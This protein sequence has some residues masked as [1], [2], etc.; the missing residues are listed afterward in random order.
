MSF[1]HFINRFKQIALWVYRGK[2]HLLSFASFILA[3]LYLIG[4]LKFYPGAI[5][6]FMTLTGL[7]IILTQQVI[8]ATKFGPHGPNTIAGWLK[9]FPTRKSITLDA[10]SVSMTTSIGK[11][12][13]TCSISEDETIEKKVDF[14]I[15]QI[16]ALNSAIAKV[17]D[18]VD[19]LNSSLKRSEKKFQT[20]VNTLST[21]LNN[22]IAS[23]VVG[24]YDVRLFGINITI[25]GTVIQFFS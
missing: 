19:E 12:H 4:F 17:D 25:C 20:S 6:I 5:A 7:L 2:F 13:L 11:A 23:H 24:S 14:L 15:R 1:R 21:T 3:A 8:D 22:V 18:R 16:T 10:D 9:S